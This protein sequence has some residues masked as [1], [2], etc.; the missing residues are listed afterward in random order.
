MSETDNNDDG[1]AHE[2]LSDQAIEESERGMK[3]A[4]TIGFVA[5]VC[6]FVGAI[7]TIA[8]FVTWDSDGGTRSVL[9]RAE[10]DDTWQSVAL[11]V[12]GIQG[13]LM[14]TVLAGIAALVRNSSR[15]LGIQALSL[16]D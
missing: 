8:G 16:V 14:A 15:S 9:A 11:L 2:R 10:P 5:A 3:L 13:L 4:G 7:A 6:G 1:G 12:G